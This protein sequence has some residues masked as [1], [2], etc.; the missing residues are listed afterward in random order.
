MN[1]KKYQIHLLIIAIIVAWAL[2]PVW[3]PFFFNIV[4]TAEKITTTSNLGT[5]GDSFGALNSLF[6]G[7]AFA[8]I[9][10]SIVLQSK[11]LKETRVDIKAQNEQFRIQNASIKRQVFENTFFQLISL[12]NEII[13]SITIE[14]LQDGQGKF[15]IE[16]GRSA[17]R[18]LYIEK[19]GKAFFRFELKLAYDKYEVP[20]N[21]NDYYL[22]FHKVYGDQVGHY[23]R[24]IY[25]ILKLIDEEE[26]ENKK[27]YSNLLRAQLNSY[28]LGLL[29][30]NCISE[31]GNERFKPLVEKYEFFEHLP[32][33]DFIADKDIKEY[34]VSAY[35]KTN[36]EFIRIHSSAEA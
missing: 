33:L 31:I 18:A 22:D 11:E 13:Q 26:I 15:Q 17:F 28:E 19:F 32:R 9:I 6:S 5:F 34:A 36:E 4:S 16:T 20:T 2:Y 7:L 29:F 8:G 27:L 21:T 14:H 25:Q 24:N 12:H 35:G 10:V 23:F 1:I 3:L 30:F